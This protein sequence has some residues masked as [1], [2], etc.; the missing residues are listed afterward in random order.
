MTEPEVARRLRLLHRGF[1]LSGIATV[2]LGPLIPPLRTLWQVSNDEMAWLFPA[3]FLS[4]ALGSVLSTRDFRRSLFVGYLSLA[5]GLLGLA[6]LVWPWA[7]GAMVLLGLGLGL[8]LPATNLLVAHVQPSDRSRAVA[9]AN[10]I[11]GLGAASSPM[12]LALAVDGLLKEYL[13]L[14]A[15]GS[16]VVGAHL[17]SAFDRR[18][19]DRIRENEPGPAGDVGAPSTGRDSWF[20]LPHLILA[21][22]FFLYI[23]VENSIGGW[24][25][26]LSEQVGQMGLWAMLVG[27]GFWASVLVGRA[28]LATGWF[29]DLSEFSLYT[30]ALALAATGL[31]LLLFGRAAPALAL[32]ALLSGFG[33]APLFPLSVSFLAELMARDGSRDTGWIFALGSCGGAVLPWLTGRVD[34]GSEMLRF[35]FVVPL[36]GL[37]GLATLLT[38][39]RRL[40]EE[41]RQPTKIAP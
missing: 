13:A 14:L 3:Q 28:L 22:M 8:I 20:S 12:F 6:F 34:G 5:L 2:L 9:K 38:A 40:T 10:L 1:F 16:L 36:V 4:A 25:I 29:R 7:L 26:D 30:G 27:S 32:G 24:L 37:V 33:L 15:A 11:W 19:F 35:G 18:T 41:S 31:A 17:A 39:F 23:G 21:A